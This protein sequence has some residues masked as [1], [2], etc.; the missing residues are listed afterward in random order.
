MKTKTTKNN[1]FREIISAWAKAMTVILR[2]I[3]KQTS[4]E[5]VEMI[6]KADKIFVAGQGRSGLIG[7]CLATRLTQIGFQVHVPGNAT[8]QKI[9]AGDLMIAIS[10]RGTTMTT[11]EFARISRDAGAKVAVITASDNSTLT[12]LADKV[13]LIAANDEKIR[14]KCKYVVGPSNNTLFEQTALLYF[15]A[16]IHIILKRKGI[17]INII[18]QKHANLE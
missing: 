12:K 15:D 16:L 5:L 8:C 9:E 6:L 11:V 2:Q 17:S 13:I 10:C 3:E 18:N 7:R 14:K 1:N 4:E